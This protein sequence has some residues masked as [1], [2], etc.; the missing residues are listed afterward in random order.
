MKCNLA[1]FILREALICVAGQGENLFRLAWYKRIHGIPNDTFYRHINSL[2]DES[3]II[4][5]SRDSYK[6]HPLFV[7]KMNEIVKEK[8]KY[9]EQSEGQ[10]TLW[11][12]IPF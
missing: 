1:L 5:I 11:S 4:R 6:L 9:E 10:L 7:G 3:F 12:E 2:I 8:P